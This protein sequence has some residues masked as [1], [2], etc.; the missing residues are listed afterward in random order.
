MPDKQ[1]IVMAY[2]HKWSN[3]GSKDDII[4]KILEGKI[5]HKAA[6]NAD[7]IKPCPVRCVE[8]DLKEKSQLHFR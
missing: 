2:C 8:S 1:K 7:M 3:I 5:E 4:V 6:P